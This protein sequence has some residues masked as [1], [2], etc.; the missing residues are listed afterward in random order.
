MTGRQDLEQ[1]AQAQEN[2]VRLA[3][4]E[5][6]KLRTTLDN[7]PPDLQ[8]D[9]LLDYIP[10]LVRKYGD[11]AAAAAADWYERTRAK[12]IEGSYDAVLADAFPDDAIR[13]DVRWKAGSL[14]DG[15]TSDMYRFLSNALDRWVRYSSRV[16]IM[17]NAARDPAKP[18][19]A[20]VPRGI[21]TCA[22]CEMLASRGFV[23][24]SK[25]NAGALDPFHPGDDCEIVCQWDARN[26]HIEGYD[27]D[28]MLARYHSAIKTIKDGDISD[29][30][31]REAKRAKVEFDSEHPSQDAILFVMRRQHPDLYSDGVFPDDNKQTKGNGSVSYGEWHHM[32]KQLMSRFATEK[33]DHGKLP[34]T[35][36][37]EAPKSWP[38][39][40]PVLTSKAWN[41][42]LYADV[43]GRAGGHLYGYGWVDAPKS[44]EF[45]EEWGPGEILESIIH[46]L[47][48]PNKEGRHGI[49]IGHYHGVEVN[50]A[51]STNRN[52]LRSV[53]SA[54]PVYHE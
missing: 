13:A 26:A 10:A 49:V 2:N 17:N 14:F 7:L 34:P 28:A 11:V 44:T 40:F 18:L 45:P 3:R 35:T 48:N 6:G 39:D 1:L 47:R 29:Q 5:L 25:E 51:V 54:Y 12:Q 52:G 32:R 41:H 46:V 4:A 53:K 20:R 15:N 24:A 16:T 50:V 36:P 9:M 19:W 21:F 22:F 38:D 30:W 8:R 23:Y 37:L 27:P 43:K 33:P 42:I 31:K